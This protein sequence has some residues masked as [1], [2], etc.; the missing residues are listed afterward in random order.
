[1]RNRSIIS[2]IS[3]FLAIASC[4]EPDPVVKDEVGFAQSGVTIS[5]DAGKGTATLT[6]NGSWRVTETPSWLSY[7]KPER[8]DAGEFELTFGGRFYEGTE[9]RSGEVKVVCG[10]AVATILVTQ[11]PPVAFSVSPESIS[12]FP[13]EGGSAE[14]A[15]ACGFRISCKYPG[16]I[17]GNISETSGGYKIS[18]TIEANSGEERSDKISVLDESSNVVQEIPVSQLA[19]TSFAEKRALEALYNDCGGKDWTKSDNWCSSKPLSDWYGVG[20][21]EKGNVTKLDLSNNNLKGELPARLA[22]LKM[23][24]ELYLYGNC[25]SGSLPA[26]MRLLDGWKSFSATKH[27]YPQ[28]SGYALSSKDSEVAQYQKASS[29]KGIDIVIMGDA[30]DKSGLELGKGFDALVEKAI[31]S[32]FAVEPMASCRDCFNV[33][34]VSAESTASEIST[35][36][37]NTAFGTYFTS[38][39]FTVVTMNTNWEKVFQ[40]AGKAPASDIRNSIVILLA[41]T[42]RFGGTTLSWEDGRRLSII[43]DF[44]GGASS[45]EAQYGFAGLVQHEAVGHAFGH[46]DEEYHTNGL[47]T[48][49]SFAS[50]LAVKHSKGFSLNIAAS[51]DLAQAPWSELA[52]KNVYSGIG[53]YEGA[54]NY[55]Y[56]AYRSEKDCCM[57]DNRP[58]FSAWCRYILWKR[59]RTISGEDASLEAFVAFEKK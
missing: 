23:L 26:G 49:A 40:Y 3:L 59:I 56:G 1:M 21:D 39:D 20:V 15:V 2:L 11:N 31:E 57:V 10:T 53:M 38:S 48:P 25:L 51:G 17:T 18:L 42:Q 16:W 52:A 30:F 29:G 37:T 33:Y 5:A 32:I 27:I 50:D 22:E 45:T 28:Q 13:A 6:A 7:V 4:G 58:Y 43:P 35:N 34:A 41:N 44:Q 47:T 12:A 14:L 24:K 19:N 55:S 54:G 36:A 9:A 46:L 8:G